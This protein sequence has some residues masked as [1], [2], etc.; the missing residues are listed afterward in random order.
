MESVV[1][2]MRQRRESLRTICFVDECVVEVKRERM[3]SKRSSR[4]VMRLDSQSRMGSTPSC[5]SLLV[6]VLL[7]VEVEVVLTCGGGCC[8][9]GGGG[10]MCAPLF[11]MAV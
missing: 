7:E 1:W 8:G 5:S 9:C 11:V 4:P 2:R 10:G 6:V 3:D